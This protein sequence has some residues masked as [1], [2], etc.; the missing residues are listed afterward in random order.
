MTLEAPIEHLHAGGEPLEGLVENPIDPDLK[1]LLEQGPSSFMDEQVMTGLRALKENDTPYTVMQF[2][3]NPVAGFKVLK[4]FWDKADA[5][6]NAKRTVALSVQ[7]IVKWGDM[8]IQADMA[9]SYQNELRK[10]IGNL[11]PDFVAQHGLE[12]A[13]KNSIAEVM[14]LIRLSA[15]LAAVPKYHDEIKQAMEL[16]VAENIHNESQLALSQM[17][18][19]TLPSL[20]ESRD[21]SLPLVRNEIFQR[22]AHVSAVAIGIPVAAVTGGLGGG[23]E[24]AKIGFKSGIDWVRAKYDSLKQGVQQRVTSLRAR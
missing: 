22:T 18:V 8:D 4:A 16:L 20:I 2:I 12:S 24:A 23:I 5:K 9:L 19:D 17:R 14:Q 15:S 13:P 6:A 11:L 3:A 1:A 10:K 21:K 7:K